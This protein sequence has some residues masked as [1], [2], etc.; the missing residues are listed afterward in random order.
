M[1]PRLVHF[2]YNLGRGGAETLIVN[3]CRNLTEYEHIIVTIQNT[4]H[5]EQELNGIKHLSLNLS[6]KEL[7]LFPLAVRKFRKLL[8]ALNPDMVHAHLLW[9]IAIARCSVPNHIPLITTIHGYV[10]QLVDYKKWYFRW[11]DK[12]TFRLRDTV[13]VAVSKGALREYLDFHGKSPSQS[14]VIY[15]FADNSKFIAGKT[16]LHNENFKLI[17]VGALRYQKNQKMLV[18]IMSH[19][20]ELPI[21]LHIYGEG[22]QR[23]DLA[24]SIKESGANVKLMGQHQ[25]LYEVLPEYDALIMTSHY[26]G[27]SIGVLEAMACQLPLILSNIPSFRE[28]CEETALY[29]DLNQP[30]QAVQHIKTLMQ[31]PSKAMQL[32]RSAQ[33]RFEQNFTKEK[34][35]EQ[36]RTLYHHSLKS[37]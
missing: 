22:D 30:Q 27:F 20:K 8:N 33:K 7:F 16:N 13:V 2:I 19:L 29:F 11:L 24:K 37:S 26:E 10:S 1:K 28:Q 31:D 4:N 25:R 17:H 18:E 32:G 9:P 15:T 34:Y 23:E 5:F 36:I 12:Y 6:L 35:L 21:E 14:K 3:T